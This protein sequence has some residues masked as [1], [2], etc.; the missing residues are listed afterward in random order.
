[1]TF[2]DDSFYGCL[3]VCIHD[4]CEIVAVHKECGFDSLFLEHVQNFGGVDV[5]A[6]VECQCYGIGNDAA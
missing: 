3:I 4:V 2:V 1:M 6:V 5:W